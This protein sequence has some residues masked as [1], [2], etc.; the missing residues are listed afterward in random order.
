MFCL[1]LT[2]HEEMQRNS[3]R[4]CSRAQM[5]HFWHNIIFKLFC[6]TGML[7]MQIDYEFVT[8]I[9]MKVAK[10]K[11]NVVAVLHV[12]SSESPLVLYDCTTLTI[13][14]VIR[15]NSQ[16][17]CTY[18]CT[19]LVLFFFFGGTRITENPCFWTCIMHDTYVYGNLQ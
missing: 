17:A 6:N 16:T 13:S 19:T 10:K 14:H 18:K 3:L 8:E 11:K 4:C 9:L 2:E 7:G 15:V 1:L 12:N 5:C